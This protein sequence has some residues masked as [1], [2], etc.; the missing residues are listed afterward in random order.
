[1]R[2]GRNALFRSLTS[3]VEEAIWSDGHIS[4]LTPLLQGRPQQYDHLPRTVYW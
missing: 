2:T 3:Y 1:M 4:L